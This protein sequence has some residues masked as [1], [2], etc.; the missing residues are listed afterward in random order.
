MSVVVSLVSFVTPCLTSPSHLQKR[1]GADKAKLDLQATKCA[2]AAK[3]APRLVV[4]LVVPLVVSPVVPLVVSLVGSVRSSV[5]SSVGSSV[6]A[7]T[8]SGF[9]TRSVYRCVV[10]S[11]VGKIMITSRQDYDHITVG[12]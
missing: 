1:R 8:G 7:S 2:V 6:N 12:M 5:S 4:S 9:V 10:V 11:T 3:E